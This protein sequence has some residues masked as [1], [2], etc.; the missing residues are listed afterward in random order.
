MQTT[1]H[2]KAADLLTQYGKAE[3]VSLCR[4]KGWKGDPERA[5][6]HMDTG[7]YIHQTDKDTQERL[8]A[9][10]ALA[11]G[12]TALAYWLAAQIT[13]DDQ[14]PSMTA[15]QSQHIQRMLD[16]WQDLTGTPY[17]AQYGA[18]TGR[19]ADDHSTLLAALEAAEYRNKQKQPAPAP[20]QPQPAPAPD[21]FGNDQPT[22]PTKGQAK[23]TSKAELLAALMAAPDPDEAAV[24]RMIDER[25]KAHQDAMREAVNG[26][27]LAMQSRY[28]ADFEN[29]AAEHIHSQPPSLIYQRRESHT[30]P[31]TVN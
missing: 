20:Q 12:K 1:L 17:A 3:L 18:L 7:A 23:M 4:A 13:K 11:T 29:L 10:D 9:L 30:T 31:P 26:A 24:Q 15:E 28:K 25:L 5:Y 22:Q 19:F 21:L 8:K 6:T 16:D 2:A 14:Q 27:S